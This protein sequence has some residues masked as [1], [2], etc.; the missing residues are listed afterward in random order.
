MIIALIAI[1]YVF[2]V[3]S[4]YFIYMQEEEL[5][6]IE[7]LLFKNLSETVVLK[8]KIS[9]LEGEKDEKNISDN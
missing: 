1:L 2:N 9:I 8:S 4:A 6:E 5:I 7:K 3:I